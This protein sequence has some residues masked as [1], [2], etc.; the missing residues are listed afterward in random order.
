V[1]QATP[2]PG[3]S[4]LPKLTVRRSASP[5]AL[6]Q[7]PPLLG[8]AKAVSVIIIT[9]ISRNTPTVSTT[10]FDLFPDFA[11]RPDAQTSGGNGLA[12]SGNGVG[13]LL[14]AGKEEAYVPGEIIRRVGILQSLD[15]PKIRS[16]CV[17]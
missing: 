9:T 4:P 5:L 8:I 17:H 1:N 13:R 14:W 2:I 6:G 15:P 10:L 11:E 3:T 12:L 16:G 7:L